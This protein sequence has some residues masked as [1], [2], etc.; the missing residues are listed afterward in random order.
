MGAVKTGRP[1]RLQTLFARYLLTTCLTMAVLALLWWTAFM[2]AMN[3]EWVLPAYTASVQAEALTKRIGEAG[4]LEPDSIPHYIRWAVFSRDGELTAHAAMK[5]RRLEQIRRAALEGKLKQGLLYTQYHRLVPM[6]GG[7]TVVL[8]Y[9][10]AV[11]YKSAG[12]AACL[13]DFQSMMLVVLAGL[14][15]GAAA[16]HTRRYARLLREDA[17]RLTQASRAIA[18]RSLQTPVSAGTHAAELEEAL[19]AMEALRLSLAESLDRQF[20]LEQERRREIAS[21]AH[22]LKTP[23]AIISGSAEL[24]EE[25]GLP[26]G[27]AQRVGAIG[28]AAERMQT[29][30]QQLQAL[31]AQMDVGEERMRPVCLAK[32]T[33]DL[34]AQGA[35]LCAARRVEFI[36]SEQP[37]G[38]GMLEREAVTRAAL[39]LLDNAA[40]YAG[41][42][43][44]V[45]LSLT[46]EGG[47]LSLTVRDSGPGFSA[48]AL[49]LAGRAFY[50]EE[51]HRSAGGHAGMGLC[52]A[53]QTALRHGGVLTLQNDSG[54]V[55]R[56]TLGRIT[57]SSTA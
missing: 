44:R 20:V 6:G 30:L 11:P 10:Y 52:Y 56:I 34:N 57:E 25:D 43:G 26:A 47:L 36:P 37:K 27:P 7:G 18:S 42:G 55:A 50:T 17:Q 9:D 3:G 24:L 14:L 15:G 31:S 22:D 38:E 33:D 39:N 13:P 48:E 2:A 29:C 40:R 12:L 4:I 5:P 16:W 54:A 49:R 51:K 19:L 28:R 53:A 32:L 8:Q 1:V 45:A 41:P 46:A 23:L 35:S 21:L